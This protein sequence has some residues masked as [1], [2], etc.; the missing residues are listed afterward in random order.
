MAKQTKSEPKT[1]NPDV[2]SAQTDESKQAPKVEWFENT[3][4]GDVFAV[5][6][7]TAAH[8][9]VSKSKNYERTDA[10]KPSKS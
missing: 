1:E 8:T 4:T 9:R 3:D 2:E 6:P 5:N 10:P 7:G